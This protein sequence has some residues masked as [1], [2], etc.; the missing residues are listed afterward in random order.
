MATGCVWVAI[1]TLLNRFFGVRPHAVSGLVLFQYSGAAD[2]VA[3]S[4]DAFRGYVWLCAL[5]LALGT[6]RTPML[7]LLQSLPP[8]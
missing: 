4:A 8:G 6:L 5:F 7:L 3:L 2:G 1:L